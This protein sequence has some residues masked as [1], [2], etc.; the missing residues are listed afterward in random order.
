M[1]PS[2]KK[3]Y[4]I[5]RGALTAHEQALVMC[6]LP[7]TQPPTEWDVR[8]VLMASLLFQYQELE[9]ADQR[10][11]SQQLNLPSDP[12]AEDVARQLLARSIVN[13]ILVRTDW[14]KQKAHQPPHEKVV[15]AAQNLTIWDYLDSAMTDR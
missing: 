6:E 14:A 7:T 1:T 2:A 13:R 10:S 3:A 9:P 8:R 12:D 5:P 11:L 4:W 15:E